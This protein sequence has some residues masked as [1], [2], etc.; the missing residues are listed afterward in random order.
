MTMCGNKK[1]TL[2]EKGSKVV[3]A[4]ELHGLSDEEEA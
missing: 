1:M 4:K 3:S 2:E